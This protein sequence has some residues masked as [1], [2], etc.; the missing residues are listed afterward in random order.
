MIVRIIGDV[1]GH[2]LQYLELIKDVPYSIQLGD[3]GYDYT[4]L[5]DIDPDNH[6]VVAGNHENFNKLT[7]HFLTGFGQLQLGGLDFFYVHG[8][9]SVDY[10][11]R[12]H[13]IDVFDEEEIDWDGLKML[14]D[15]WPELKPKIVV[16]HTCPA[17]LIK[18]VGCP[19]WAAK[20]VGPS[21]TANALQVC[22]EAWQPEQW[23]FGHYHKSF[24]EKMN[25][26]HFHCLDELEVYDL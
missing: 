9:F 24:D 6:K 3:M 19:Y 10:K 21:R 18:Y 8:A 7:P 23:F 25:G 14:V 5:Y 1:H 17:D 13:G 15:S 22:W 20:G 4:E 2:T 11:M 12:T 16:S 26:T